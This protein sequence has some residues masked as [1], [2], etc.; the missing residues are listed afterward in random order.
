MQTITDA[1]VDKIADA[2]NRARYTDS[3]LPVRGLAEED[4]HAQRYARTLARAAMT[5]MHEAHFAAAALRTAT[6]SWREFLMARLFGERVADDDGVVTMRRWRGKL[7]F[8]SHKP[9]AG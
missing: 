1:A 5:A 7:Y 4:E 3:T 9:N 8:I 6:V 2:I